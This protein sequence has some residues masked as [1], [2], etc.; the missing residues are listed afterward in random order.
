ME[1]PERSQN[2]AHHLATW[3]P[4]WLEHNNA[5]EIQ[6]QEPDLINNEK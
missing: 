6:D 1:P 2:A 3:N 5:L 4:S